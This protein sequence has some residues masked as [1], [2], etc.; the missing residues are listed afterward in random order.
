MLSSLF[1]DKC[2]EHEYS[3]AQMRNCR[4]LIFKNSTCWDFFSWLAVTGIQTQVNYR[5]FTQRG[6]FCPLPPS[7]DL[8]FH[9]NLLSESKFKQRKLPVFFFAQQLTLHSIMRKDGTLWGPSLGTPLREPWRVATKE[10]A[11]FVVAPLPVEWSPQWG[12]PGTNTAFWCQVKIFLFSQAFDGIWSN[13]VKVPD[14]VLLTPCEDWCFC[15]DLL[16]SGDHF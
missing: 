13:W 14:K 2:N 12:L 9:E 8:V 5:K 7:A 1:Q 11:F 10:K 6:F 4:V 16:N 15:I 3:A